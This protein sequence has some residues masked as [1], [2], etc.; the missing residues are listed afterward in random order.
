M[1]RVKLDI[2]KLLQF[3]ETEALGGLRKAAQRIEMSAK[4]TAPVGTT[5]RRGAAKPKNVQFL[6]RKG[7]SKTNFRLVKYTTTRPEIRYP[8]QL[9]DSI[10]IVEKEGKRFNL[11]VYAGNYNAYYAHMIERGTIH[12]KAFLVMKSAL[13]A[14]RTYARRLINDAMKIAVQRSNKLVA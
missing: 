11:R 7:K 13:D 8:G 12:N 4:M 3:A 10:R 14:N 9:R 2:N 1:A 5:F 6:A